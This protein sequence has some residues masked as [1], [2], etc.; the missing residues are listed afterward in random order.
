MVFEKLTSVYFFQIVLKTMPLAVPCILKHQAYVS[1]N[2]Q[3]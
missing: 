2:D 3:H 1:D